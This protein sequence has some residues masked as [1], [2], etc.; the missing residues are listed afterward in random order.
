MSPMRDPWPDP[1]APRADE[2]REAALAPLDRLAWFLDSAVRIPGTSVRV[3]A[4]AAANLLPGVGP[5]VSKGGSAWLILEAARLGAPR[6]LLLRMAGHVA[7]DAAIGAVPV[8]GW[9]ADIALRANRR[10]INLLREH[11]ARSPPAPPPR[12]TQSQPA[13]APAPANRN[14]IGLRSP[15]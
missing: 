11:L 12:A 6:A 13:A 10:N 7:L 4:D 1:R 2:A 9:A 3:G 15:A 8:F 5:L 14:D